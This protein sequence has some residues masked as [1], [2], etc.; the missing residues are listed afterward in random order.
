M[1]NS[2][3]KNIISN[4]EELS[5][6]SK[7]PSELV[8][9]KAINYIDEHC[10]A[11]IAKAPLL[12]I[13]TAHADGS[14]D[15]SPRGD[16]AGFV[17]VIDDKHLIIPERPGNRRFDTLRNILSNPHVGLIFVIPGLKETLRINGR[18]VL[19]QD[20]ALLEKLE[21]QGKRPRLGIGI[22]VEECFIHCAKAFIRS[23][24]WDTGT[25][26]DQE[27]LPNA[28]KILTDHINSPNYKEEDI[29]EALEESY[30]KRL[31]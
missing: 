6:L 22:E 9:Q 2:P 13:S 29:K 5:S 8:K 31:Y 17:Y 7:P 25:W 10:K 1:A 23:S 3:F 4:E 16:S 11:Y 20:D 19:T 15:V 12:F 30:T 26:L 18:A 14:C 28:T 21:A 27:N 24:I